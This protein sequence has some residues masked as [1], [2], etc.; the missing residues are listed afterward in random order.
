MKLVVDA[1][2]PI[3]ANGRHTN[4]SPI[5]QL[6]AIGFLQDLVDA[7]SQSQ[8][9][10]DAKGLIFKEYKNHLSFAGQ[11]GVGDVFLKFL[12]DHL[13]GGGRVKLIA[14]TQIADEDR[15][16]SELPPN[17]L[18]KSDRKFLAVAAAHD[19]RPPILQAV[20]SKWWG[21][22]KALGEIGVTVHFL[23]EKEIQSKYREKMG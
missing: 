2:V 13:Y 7:K 18:D 21:W 12:N 3:V 15:G 4:A 17:T 19:E 5:C 11:P 20:D 23:C 16:F 9:F 10:V 22:Q 14:I 1:N 8:L 6:N